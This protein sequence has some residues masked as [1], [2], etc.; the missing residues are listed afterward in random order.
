MRYT[1]EIIETLCKV[2]TVD[3]PTEDEA[4]VM[5]KRMYRKGDIILYAED[6]LCTEIQLWEDYEED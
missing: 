2:V 4:Y 6:Y 3:A 5:V 1:Y